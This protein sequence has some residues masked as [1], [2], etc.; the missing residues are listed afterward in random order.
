[1]KI[2]NKEFTDLN[3]HELYSILKLRQE[4]FIIEQECNYLDCD[5]FDLNAIHVT[6]NDDLNLIAYLRI[7]KHGIISKNIVFGRILVNK[8]NRDK[9]IG[10]NIISYTIEFVKNK[11]PNTDIEMSAQS[12]LIEYYKKFGFD[13]YGEEYLEDEIPHIKM[14]KKI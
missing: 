8:K 11:F 2:E 5:N 12:Y 9:S 14:I 1:M 10:K 6:I 3:I 13:V 7:I 4:V